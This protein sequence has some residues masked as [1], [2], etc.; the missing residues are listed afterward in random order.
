MKSLQLFSLLLFLFVSCGRVD[1]Q[2]T[3][4][5]HRPPQQH[6]PVSYE[7]SQYDEWAALSPQEVP[8][9]KPQPLCLADSFQS[10]T[11]QRSTPLASAR[12]IAD[13]S[14]N[15]PDVYII[16]PGDV[17]EVHVWNRPDISSSELVVGPDGYVSLQRIGG[18]YV[19]G[20]TRQQAQE[21]LEEKLKEFYID[22]QVTLSVRLYNNNRAFVLGRVIQPGIVNFK[23]PGSLIEALSLAGGI[24]PSEGSPTYTAKCSIIRGDRQIIW[25]DL[26]E[27]LYDGNLALNARI[28]NDD[29]IY[30]PAATQKLVYVMGAVFTPN[31]IVYTPEMSFMDALMMTG[32]PT[33]DAKLK[34]TFLLRWD[35]QERAVR[36]VNL[37]HMLE[38]GDMS[39]NYLLQPNDIIFVS[40]KELATLNYVLRQISPA[41]NTILLAND[42]M[43]SDS[44]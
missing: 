39:Q 29:I 30:V 36:Q 15:A 16:G 33:E 35:G 1:P 25:V 41:L 9:K 27:L 8:F 7:E 23:G 42:L 28:Q 32:G 22:P 38:N 19:G 10:K 17:I 26:K 44:N 13:L 11:T 40:E 14:S 31:A 18:V 24:L 4:I 21:A 2:P 6:S 20:M 37:R 43:N 5:H 12:A 3:P 34:N